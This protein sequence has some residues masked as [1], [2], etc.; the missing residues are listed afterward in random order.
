[1]IEYFGLPK[2]EKSKTLETLRWIG[3]SEVGQKWYAKAALPNFLE[4]TTMHQTLAYGFKKG[5]TT[6]DV[7]GLYREIIKAHTDWEG[8]DGVWITIQD[9]KQAFDLSLIHI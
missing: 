5:C 7:V 8:S 4:E 3:K 1:M 9:V 6:D 2:G